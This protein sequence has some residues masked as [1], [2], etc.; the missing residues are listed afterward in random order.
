[1]FWLED[2]AYI[3]DI[4]QLGYEAAYPKDLSVVHAGGS[5]YAPESPEKHAYWRRYWER[6]AR[7]NAIKRRCCE[8]RSYAL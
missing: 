3:A 4:E 5:Y 1:M 7:R 2:E 8:Y 6:E